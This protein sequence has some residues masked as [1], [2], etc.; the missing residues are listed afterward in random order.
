MLG[1][2]VVGE[3][4]RTAGISVYTLGM[5]RGRPSIRAVWQ[6]RSILGQ[7]H[8]AIMQTWMYHA[9]LLG[10]LVGALTRRP[11]LIWCVHAAK[12]DVTQYRRLTGWTIRFCVWL[13][14]LPR[15]V[16]VNSEATYRDHLNLG[17][18]PRQWKTIANG[19][20]L[21]KF[22][23]DPS[24]R[25]S[26]RKEL[27]LSSET[28]LIGLIARY[29]PM[30]DHSTFLQAAAKLA[31][32]EPNVHFVLAGGGVTDQNATLAVQID[33]LQL[34]PR[35]HLLGL[36]AD[37][38]RI[39][40]A[41]DIASSSSSFGESFSNSTAEAMAC[42]VPCVVTD[43]ANLPHLIGDTG[44]AV[45]LKD[46]AALAKGWRQLMAMGQQERQRLGQRARRRIEQHYSL[47]RMV[48]GYEEL[49]LSL[50]ECR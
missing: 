46:P 17:Y 36:R 20:D 26:L 23:P 25:S 2:G 18:R 4:I 3:R 13:S 43:V 22:K 15:V 27:N 41:L 28:L 5:R 8:P 34:R 10:T 47:D 21:G 38:P 16:V 1:E 29:D 40:A 12:L 32:V 42:G 30:K 48:R 24:A 14:R 35:V 44:L 45:P 33:R 31:Q 9:D 6:L 37:M 7:E 50:G 39:N 19:F 49:Y 11:P